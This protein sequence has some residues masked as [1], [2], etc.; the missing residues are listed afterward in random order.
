MQDDVGERGTAMNP[1]GVLALE[2]SRTSE[3]QDVRHFLSSADSTLSPPPGPGW[4]STACREVYRNKWIAVE[5]HAAVAPT[6]ADANYGVVRFQNLAI[7]VMPLFPDGST[8]LV[9]QHR[10]AR[11]NYSWELPEGG[12]PLSDDPLAGA[13]RELKEETGLEAKTWLPAFAGLELS[14]SVTDERA[15][16][17]IALDLTQSEAEPDATES[18]ALRRIHFRDALDLA[19]GGVLKDVMTVAML[20]QVYHMA[21]EGELPA[22]LSAALLRREEPYADPP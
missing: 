6:G 8:V 20:Y 9:G 16:G 3:V 11:M 19:R 15:Y 1:D 22:E 12:S 21:A 2:S 13:V 7:A 14:N 4:R 10:F 18:L 5:E 17:F